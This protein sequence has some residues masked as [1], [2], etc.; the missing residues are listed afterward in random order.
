VSKSRKV[1]VVNKGVTATEAAGSLVHEA[2]HIRQGARKKQGDYLETFNRE[3]E[4]FTN[5]TLF[6]KEL[7]SKPYNVRGAPDFYTRNGFLKV[8]IL[9][10]EPYLTY[11]IQ[12]E[13]IEQFVHTQYYADA[14][15]QTVAKAEQEINKAAWS[16]LVGFGASGS[17]LGGV[18][19][20]TAKLGQ[21]APRSSAEA[22]ASRENVKWDEDQTPL[23]FDARE[24]GMLKMDY[25]KWERI[26]FQPAPWKIK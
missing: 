18:A 10:A 22:I 25:G 24:K 1:Q 20:L 12:H 6:I 4:A 13:K 2:T 14:A 19:S 16:G 7:L 9:D 21:G 23:P 15:K 5:E 8:K 11:E 3:V 17:L 26:T